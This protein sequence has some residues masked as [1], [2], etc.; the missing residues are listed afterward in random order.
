[1]LIS[2]FSQMYY[3]MPYPF[4]VIVTSLI[5]SLKNMQKYGSHFHRYYDFL[6]SNDIKNQQMK[7]DKELEKFLAHLK[8]KNRF[9]SS[10]IPSDLDIKKI[11]IVDK[12]FVLKNFQK[13]I[14]QKPYKIGK[15]SGTTGQ[16]LVVPYSKKAYQA[17]YAFWWYHWSF[18]NVMRGDKIATFG[19]H[20][21]SDVNRDSPPFWVYNAAEN[22][23]FFSSY[24]L[25]YRNLPHYIEKLNAYKPVFIYGYPSTLYLL[26]KYALENSI[27]IEFL[28]KMIVT[29]SER[30]YDFQR[31]AIENAFE[32]KL[33]ILYGN[34]EHC[35][36]ITECPYGRLHIQPY[37][38]QVRVIR[39]DGEEAKKCEIGNIV[40]TN[41]SN[42]SFPLINYDT[43]DIVKISANQNCQCN[44]GGMIIDYIQGRIEDYIITPEGRIVVRMGHLFKNA[45]FIRNAQIQQNKV[46]Q[47]IL[48][49]EKEDGYTKK[50]EKAILAEAKARLGNSI[51]IDFEY[52]SKIPKERNGKFRFIIQ[53]I[54]DKNSLEHC[55]PSH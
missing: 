43:K 27:K 4:K 47:V 46:N 28:P 53:K 30:T 6:M 39:E 37:H 16:P 3:P 55:F 50:D 26:A 33:F 10:R 20:K 32:S 36:L 35:G 21:I 38:S 5:G 9:F 51:E 45:K 19:G 15:T 2:N 54:H 8:R 12:N 34:V 48:R 44:N 1:M 24:H 42:Y 22:Q 41:F 23:M 14:M 7:A 49:I 31:H 52:V 25:S 29:S 17:E 40:G 18:G 11:P 13:I